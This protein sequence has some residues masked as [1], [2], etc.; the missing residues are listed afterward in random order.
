MKAIELLKGLDVSN[1]DIEEYP[2]LNGVYIRDQRGHKS[3]GFQHAIV[4]AYKFDMMTFCACDE[5]GVYLF[6][7]DQYEQKKQQP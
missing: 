7:R 6:I 1:M 5:K 2:D 4:A 3:V